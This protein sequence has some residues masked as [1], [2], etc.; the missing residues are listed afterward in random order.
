MFLLSFF[1]LYLDALG[2]WCTFYTNNHPNNSHSAK[3]CRIME[4]LC[5]GET[6]LP[7][8]SNP[9]HHDIKVFLAP[10]TF[11]IFSQPKAKVA[12]NC[13]SISYA[14]HGNT[15]NACNTATRQQ[16]LYKKTWMLQ[17]NKLK[18]QQLNATIIISWSV[19][20]S[21]QGMGIKT[22]KLIISSDHS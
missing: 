8:S 13:C 7:S 22:T 17:C 18:V 21:Q 5:N 2:L 20:V 10:D 11:W 12:L 16:K 15:H 14:T 3:R 1:N 19:I 4:I 6:I 9:K